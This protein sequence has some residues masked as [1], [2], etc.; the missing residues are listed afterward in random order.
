MRVAQRLRTLLVLGRVSNLPTV[1]SNCLAAWLLGGAG[2]WA[3]WAQLGVGASLLYTGGMFLNDAFDARYDR[4]Y[5]PERPIPSGQISRKT[6]AILGAVGLAVG[7]LSLA[8]LGVAAALFAL[9]LAAVIV[10][11]DVFHKRLTAAPLLMAA[12]RYLL[13]PLAASAALRGVTTDVWWR[14]LALGA[15][16]AGISLLARNESRRSSSVASRGPIALLLVPLAVA[17]VAGA[18]QPPL[19]WLPIIGLGAW[20]AWCLRG[21]LSGLKP[22]LSRGVSGLL[23][24]I[25]LVDWLAAADADLARAAIFAAL[26]LLAL[27]L[28]RLVPAT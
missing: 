20:I 17:L 15:Y 14:A 3:A 28:Q 11:Y 5:R 12:C 13:Y 1:W 22:E 6:V 7:W 10:A 4:Q 19:P 24:G 18:L 16:V 26:W 9:G 27:A 23:A 25:V 21:A 8:A 2:P